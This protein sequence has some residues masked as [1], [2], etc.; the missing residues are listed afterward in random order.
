MKL[1]PILTRAIRLLRR[2]KYGGAIHI[3]EP[4]V[5][6]YRDSFTYCYALGAAYLYSGNF[7]VALDYF[8]RAR[9]IKMR[10]PSVLLGLAVLFLR[11]GDTDRAVDLY[12][13]VQEQDPRNRTVKRA[14]RILRKYSGLENLSLWVDSGK[15]P[16]LYPPLPRLPLSLDR[17]LVPGLCLLLVLALG[18]GIML[19]WGVF[20]LPAGSHAPVRNGLSGSALERD[21]RDSPVQIGGSYRYILTRTQVLDSYE[22]GRRLFTEYRDEAAKLALNRI[23]ESNAAEAI[24]NKARTLIFYTEIPGFDTLKDRF[25]YAE[26]IRDPA[27]YRDCHVIWRGMATKLETPENGTSFDFLVGYDTRSTLEGIVPVTFDFSVSVNQERPLEVLGRIVPVS[28][29]KGEDIRLEGVALHQAGTLGNGR[30]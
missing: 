3:L 29:P 27:L 10:D 15:L 19:K 12:L 5:V 13:E 18:G 30:P 4:E 22:E 20:S 14:M 1:D 11:R 16:T 7:M 28:T 17:L 25:T 26:V 6:R 23:L 2:G 8:K 21:E 24:K 9:N